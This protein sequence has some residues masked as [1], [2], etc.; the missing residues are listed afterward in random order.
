MGRPAFLFRKHA[1][2]KFFV[3]NQVIDPPRAI[4]LL[5]GFKIPIFSVGRITGVFF[6]QPDLVPAPVVSEISLH[7]DI[8][9]DHLYLDFLTTK[10]L[11]CPEPKSPQGVF[12]VKAGL[13]VRA[14]DK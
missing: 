5:P 7:Y 1:W 11:F 2:G 6:G 14:V 8:N 3:G 4:L 12:A 9:D 10:E 13:T